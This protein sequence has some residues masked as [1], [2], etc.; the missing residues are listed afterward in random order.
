MELLFGLIQGILGFGWSI[1]TLIFTLIMVAIICVIAVL[2][3]RSALLWGIAGFFFP[4]LVIVILLLPTKYPK[5]SSELRNHPAFQGKNPVIASIM[6]LAAMIAKTDGNI[7]K[8]EVQV[9][10]QWVMANF[11]IQGEELDRYAEAFDYGK[12]HPE[13][14]TTFA[15]FIGAYYR[16]Y[17]T[18]RRIA[19]MLMAVAGQDGQIS[20]K[21]DEKLRQILGE[22]GISDYEY[23]GYKAQFT[24][25]NYEQS[26]YN[27][28]GGYGNYGGSAGGFTQ[29]PSQADLVKR[30]TQV[31]GVSEDAP[32][33]EIKKAYRKLVK[34]YHPDK[35][36][37]EH[38]PDDYVEFANKKIIE[39]NEAY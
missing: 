28:F 16:D 15:R 22:M 12:Q 2:K 13:A 36:A 31:L 37:S 27:G 26:G 7:T 39:I 8:D 5:L 20:D 21:E 38:M 10:R 14:Y 19:Y 3:R 25:Q 29:G 11:G 9:I 32:M 35:L 17:M 24:Q 33:A 6:A 34:E 23:L 4:W 30:Y 1:I 18:V